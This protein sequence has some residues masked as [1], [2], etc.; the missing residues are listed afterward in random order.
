MIRLWVSPTVAFLR[1]TA[2]ET[3]KEA[4]TQ[5]RELVFVGVIVAGK[6]YVSTFLLVSSVVRLPGM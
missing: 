5:L 4:N 3:L 1:G 2:D 6:V